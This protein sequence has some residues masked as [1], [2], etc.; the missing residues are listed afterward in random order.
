MIERLEESFRDLL[1]KLVDPLPDEPQGWA[2][3][4]GLFVS[5]LLFIPLHKVFS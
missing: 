3:V 1:I 4:A 2:F 5:D